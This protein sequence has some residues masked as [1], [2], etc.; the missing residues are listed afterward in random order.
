[1]QH[2]GKLPPPGFVHDDGT[3]VTEVFIAKQPG[4][5]WAEPLLRRIAL[6]ARRS[7]RRYGNVP[8][9]DRHD[10]QSTILLVRT[11]L[12][13]DALFFEEWLSVRFVHGELL[14]ARDA[15]RFLMCRSGTTPV[16]RILAPLFPPEHTFL[17]RTAFISRIAGIPSPQTKDGKLTRTAYAFA[18]AVSAFFLITDRRGEQ[19]DHLLGI[20]RDEL[21]EHSLTIERQGRRVPT[22][23]PAHHIIGRNPS[24]RVVIDRQI[25]A[26]EFPTYFFDIRKV[27]ELL[28]ELLR[29]GAISQDALAPYVGG[30]RNVRS[31]EAG[32]PRPLDCFKNLGKLFAHSDGP[33][34]GSTLTGAS[35]RALIDA[36]VPDGPHLRIILR[37][38]WRREQPFL[39]F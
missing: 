30:K 31:I 32:R 28:R 21:I 26:Y 11:E 17:K 25:V 6:R 8:L 29:S 22:F 24:E 37:P 2:S 35:L 3:Y 15:H 38:T 4:I 1:M 36:R 9:V 10:D 39:I 23:Y 13:R 18:H 16:V 19:I 34:L 12:T 33:I 14:G 5:T 7:Y 20:Y 27:E